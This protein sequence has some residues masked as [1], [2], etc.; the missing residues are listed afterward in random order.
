[1]QADKHDELYQ[2]SQKLNLPISTIVGR[3]IKCALEDSGAE[4]DAICKFI[5]AFL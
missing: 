2:L 3:F 4:V 5:R 1:M